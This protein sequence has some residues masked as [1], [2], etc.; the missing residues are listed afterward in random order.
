ML[1]TRQ[2]ISS[3]PYQNDDDFWRVRDLLIETYPITPTGFNW[4]IRRWDG[5][6]CHHENLDW[7]PEWEKRVHLWETDDRKLVAAVHPEGQGDAYLELH[8]DYRQL[9]DAM[10]WWAEEHLAVL[11]DH[12]HRRQLDVF[13]CD[14]DIPRRRVLAQHDFEEMPHGGVTRRMRFGNMP[15]PE[16]VIAPNYTLRSTRPDDEAECQRVADVLNA[17]FNRT[18]HTA[19]EFCMFARYSPSFRHDLNLVAEAP[20]GS[21]AALVG[22]TYDEVNRRGLFEPVCTHPDHR[23]KRLA[24][25]LMV[26]GLHRLR[27]LGATDV[28]VDTGDAVPANA[29]Y[30]AVG[31]TEAYTGHVWRKVF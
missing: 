25:A 16:V 2:H 20:D 5:W 3:R 4:E 6:R 28:Y 27:A 21:F 12:G 15:L 26:E 30:D 18:F 19:K 1:Q 11:T 13:A 22:V 7:N 10:L 9:E 14:Y 8:P 23:R 29:L 17:A 31:F 24:R